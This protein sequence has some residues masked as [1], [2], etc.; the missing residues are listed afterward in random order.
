LSDTIYVPQLSKYSYAFPNPRDASAQ[1]L[2]AW[3]GDLK[4]DRVLF[5]YMNGI[6][7]WYNADDP[8]L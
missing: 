8:I 3:G 2:I 6:F 1:G 5:A 4:R 7:P